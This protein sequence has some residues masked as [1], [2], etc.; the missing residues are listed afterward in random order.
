LTREHLTGFNGI[1]ILGWDQIIHDAQAGIMLEAFAAGKFSIP[2]ESPIDPG[3]ELVGELC[4]P[5]LIFEYPA[6]V[7]ASGSGI[8]WLQSVVL[9][10][11]FDPLTRVLAEAVGADRSAAALSKLIDELAIS[12]ALT[13]F[14]CGGVILV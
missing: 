3:R 9:E 11:A 4:E 14:F 8:L 2:S 13:R 12:P 6:W 1:D 7:R 10:S 5:S